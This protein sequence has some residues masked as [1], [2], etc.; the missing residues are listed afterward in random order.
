MEESVISWWLHDTLSR[1]E[2]S[3][4]IDYASGTVDC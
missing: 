1:H 4:L 3:I 2:Q